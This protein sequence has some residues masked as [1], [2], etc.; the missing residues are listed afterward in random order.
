MRLKNKKLINFVLLFSYV[1]IL[2]I[3][4]TIATSIG[5]IAPHIMTFIAIVGVMILVYVHSKIN[6]YSCP[7]CKNAFKIGFIKD[8]FSPNHPK[9]KFLNCPKCGYKGLMQEVDN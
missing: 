1:A 6:S 5:G 3:G 8:L 9:G 7:K 4:F 2:L